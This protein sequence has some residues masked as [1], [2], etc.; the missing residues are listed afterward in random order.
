VKQ[1]LVTLVV[2]PLVASALFAALNWIL[3]RRGSSFPLLASVASQWLVMYL[4]WTLVLGLVEALGLSGTPGRIYYTGYG[5][6][7]FALVFGV[8]QYRLARAGERTG[9]ARVFLWSQ[10]GWLVLVLAERG[11]LG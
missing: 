4:V 8:W 7:L 10:F 9:A 11:V 5:F 6:G 1:V 3:R 2:V